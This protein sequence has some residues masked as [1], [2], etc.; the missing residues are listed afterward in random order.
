M[1][2]QIYMR[3]SAYIAFDSFQND[4]SEC[5]C[6]LCRFLTHGA[7]ELKAFFEE[8]KSS[9]KR[10]VCSMEQMLNAYAKEV[11]LVGRRSKERKKHSRLVVRH[12]IIYI[13]VYMDDDN[14]LCAHTDTPNV[15]SIESNFIPLTCRG[16]LRKFA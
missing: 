11:E 15:H 10:I 9:K 6:M 1:Y 2:I 12:V 5:Q 13:Y 3:Y 16:R 8:K 7:I 14:G 4:K